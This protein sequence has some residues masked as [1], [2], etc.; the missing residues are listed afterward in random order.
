MQ[1][2][3]KHLVEGKCD[4]CTNDFDKE[5][6]ESDWCDSHK[7]YKS[8]HCDGCGKENWLKVKFHGSGHDCVLKREESELES[9]LRKVQES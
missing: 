6:W 5:K 9:V 4:Y 7:H 8:L 3:P 2:L 1:K